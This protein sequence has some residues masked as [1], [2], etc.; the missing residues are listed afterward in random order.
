MK[1][2]SERRNFEYLKIL[3]LAATPAH[4][5]LFPLI[6]LSGSIGRI[7]CWSFSFAAKFVDEILL[8]HT[9]TPLGVHFYLFIYFF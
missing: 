8:F 4:A 3:F 2:I 9:H 1:D 5:I 7:V 6:K